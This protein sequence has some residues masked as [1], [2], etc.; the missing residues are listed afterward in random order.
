MDPFLGE[1]KMVGFPFA[2]NGYAFC[3]GT[4]MPISQNSA[5]FALLGTTFG[6]NGVQTFNLPD[7]RGRSPVGMGNGPG[8]TPIVQGEVAGTENAMITTNQMPSHTHV[9]SANISIPAIA[10]DGTTPAPG[11]TMFLGTVTD[12]SGQGSP[13]SLY[14]AGTPNTNLQPFATPVTVALTGGNA[15]VPLRNPYLG[16]NFIIALNGVFPSRQ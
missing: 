6:G 7:M 14:V 11:P 15:P 9:A 2:P 12:P 10:A 5:L 1:I 8:L 13:A 16:T 4:V 3:D